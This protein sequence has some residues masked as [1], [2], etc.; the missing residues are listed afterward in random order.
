LLSKKGQTEKKIGNG[1]LRASAYLENYH[2][3]ICFVKKESAAGASRL[4]REAPQKAKKTVI[5]EYQSG[6]RL[7]YSL[8]THF[9]SD[10]S[11]GYWES[12]RESAREVLGKYSGSTREVLGKYSGSTGQGTGEVSAKVLERL[13]TKYWR[14]T[15]EV[16]AKYWPLVKAGA[17]AGAGVTGAV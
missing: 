16:L 12:S 17:P 10:I 5:L 9:A 15:G 14:S 4:R 13:L 7:W 8:G 2:F 11:P 1:T 6:H 3:I